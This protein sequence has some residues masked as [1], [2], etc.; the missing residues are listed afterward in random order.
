MTTRSTSCGMSGRFADGGSGT[1]DVCVIA[2][3]TGGVTR[4]RRT[5][6]EVQLRE[7]ATL[8]VLHRDVVGALGLAGVVDGDDVGMRERGRVL[9]LAGEALDELVVVRV[10][11]V[12]DLDRHPPAQLLVLGEV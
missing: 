1:A 11:L 8:E 5:T 7:R 2:I 4:D 9:R 3:S 12:E 10:A 6:R